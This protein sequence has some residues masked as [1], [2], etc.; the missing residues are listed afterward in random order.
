MWPRLTVYRLIW[1]QPPA[2]GTEQ[3]IQPTP[4]SRANLVSSKASIHYAL[5]Q[6]LTGTEDFELVSFLVIQSNTC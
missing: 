6:N 1:Q 4:G 2:R 5:T 3:I